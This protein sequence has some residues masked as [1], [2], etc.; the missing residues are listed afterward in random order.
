MSTSARQSPAAFELG[1]FIDGIPALAWS[2]L[3]DRS[4]DFVNRSFRDYTGLSAH[5]LYGS[6]WKSSIHPDDLPQLEI[7]WRDAAE[8]LQAGT[9]E[10]RLR[11]FDGEYRWFQISAAPL[12]DDQGNLLRWYGLNTDIDDR[13]RAE[14]KL[15]QDESD[16]RTITDAIRQSI[17]VLAPDGATLYAN[18]VALDRT[19]LTA[20]EVID[21]S[22][23][24][25]AFHPDDVE[26]MQEE[27]R[28][29]LL[30]GL[31]FELE[32]RSL[33]KDGQYRWQLIQ[34][35]PLLDE[36][37]RIIRW[38][39]TATDIDDRKKT[40]EQ[41]RNENLVLRDEIDRS[42]MFE[43]IVGSCKPMRQVLQ[44]VEKV[45]PSDSTVLILGET[46]TGKELIARALHRRSK[47]ASRA[48]IRVNCAA[49]PQSL[50]ASELFGHEKGAFT[51]AL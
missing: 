25:R 19:G 49:I 17:V 29:G 15:R 38:Y 23:L 42:S 46:G 43:E 26:R 44:Q 4:L 35:N 18:R 41:L 39:A 33:Q 48:F 28:I 32:M 14:Q 51:G 31:P 24:A 47:R 1:S 34:Y 10:V 37:G 8:S 27:R 3:P 5:Q 13:K 21:K 6:Q 7:W 22:F 20:G 30:E 50:I 11:R 2:A 36:Q 9:A 16:L 45:A 40:E 12:H